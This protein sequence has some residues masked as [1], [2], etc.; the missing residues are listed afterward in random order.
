MFKVCAITP[1]DNEYTLGKYVTEERAKEVLKEIINFFSVNDLTG[2]YEKVDLQI[3]IVKIAR[4]EMP[5]EWDY[6]KNKRWCWFK[7]IRKV[8]I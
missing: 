3:K 5:K 1:S 4:Y 2:V 8:W 7:R 6:A